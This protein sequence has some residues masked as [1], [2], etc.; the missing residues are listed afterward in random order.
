M[1]TNISAKGVVVSL[2]ASFTYP[3]GVTLL[4][5]SHD[6]DPI[7]VEKVT[8]G[9][10]A[11][12]VN[13]NLIFWNTSNPSLLSLAVLPG[14]PEAAILNTLFQINRPKPNSLPITDIITIITRFPDFTTNTYKN[15]FC[16]AGHP[17][18]SVAT[19]QNK[20]TKVFTFS[21]ESQ[22]DLI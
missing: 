1:P 10:T 21:F 17:G 5:F 18:Q 13:G 12:E 15:G 20:K 4:N 2:I 22:D 11:S 14:T 19:Q 16:V 9:E 6:T 3:I 7:D 8:I